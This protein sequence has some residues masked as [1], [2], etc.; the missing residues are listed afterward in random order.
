[1]VSKRTILFFLSLF[2][3][4]CPAAAS[5]RGGVVLVLSGGGTRGL[6]HIGVI[7]VLKEKGIPIAGIVGTSMGAIIGGLANIRRLR[8]RKR[9][10]CIQGARTRCRRG[11]SR[12]APHDAP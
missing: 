10:G 8:N 12:Q 3:F 2:L 1:M 5:A 6:A 7:E 4:L 11:I 9:Y